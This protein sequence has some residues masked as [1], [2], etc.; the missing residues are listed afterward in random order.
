MARPHEAFPLLLFQE[1]WMLLP[2]KN[3]RDADLVRLLLSLNRSWQCLCSLKSLQ[4]PHLIPGKSIPAGNFIHST[5]F[6][7]CLSCVSMSATPAQDLLLSPKRAQGSDPD[8][9]FPLFPHL[10]C[11]VGCFYTSS[12]SS[13]QH[14]DALRVFWTSSHL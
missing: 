5:G 9:S 6:C 2:W 8:H 13:L 1:V 4:I 11:F 14:R 10:L 3:W 7:S 12:P